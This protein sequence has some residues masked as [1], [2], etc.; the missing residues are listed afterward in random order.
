MRRTHLT[1]GLAL[2]TLLAVAAC[3]SPHDTSKGREWGRTRLV[4]DDTGGKLR[5][6]AENFAAIDDA[7][8]RAGTRDAQAAPVPG[9][10]HLRTTRF[11]AALGPRILEPGIDAKDDKAFDFW[12]GWLAS[13]ATKARSYEL[14]N[15]P[16]PA[17]AALRSRLG[18]KPEAVVEDCTALFGT[19]DKQRQET[20]EILGSTVNVPDHYNDTFRVI[21]IYPLMSIAVKIAFEQWK[22]R[23]LPS[24]ARRPSDLKTQG[25]IVRFAPAADTPPMRP[26]EVADLL[27]RQADNPLNT[28]RPSNAELHRLAATFAPVFAIDVTGNYDRIGTPTLTPDGVPSLDTRVPRAYVQPSW[29][30]FNGVPLLQINYLVWFSERPPTSGLDIL[31]GHLDGVIWRVTIGRNGRPVLYDS[32]H[33]CGCYHLFF[34]V[35]PTRLKDHPIDEPGEG[36]LVPTHAPV[37]GPS[38]R[39]VLH[40]GSGNHYLRG[41][42]AAKMDALNSTRYE[43]ASMDLLR[44]LPSPTGGTRS[45]YDQQGIVAGTDRSERFLLWPMGILSP[46]AMRQWGTHATAFVGR[47]H[48]DDPYLID[49]AFTQ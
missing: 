22:E 41:I 19:F 16:A 35:P 6:C 9:F 23:N 17:R 42:S 8:D 18:K 33:A 4:I 28:P 20:R 37:L 27:R 49:K 12:N 43:L 3:T 11:L 47:R 29:A 7:V 14:A 2:L 13:T 31:A 15:L 30:I 25:T 24:F 32:I 39:M 5:G 44:S 21:G 36:T 10:P 38:Q 1:T 26:Q 34:P 45:L 40:I 46:G 48:F